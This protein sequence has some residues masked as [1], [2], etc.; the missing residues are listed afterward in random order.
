MSHMTV[1]ENQ[2]NFHNMNLS[3]VLLPGAMSRVG[4]SFLCDP[5]STV[6]IARNDCVW[7][8]EVLIF[9]RM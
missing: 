3:L 6:V 2:I 4:L 9:H 1:S 8:L 7:A 5:A